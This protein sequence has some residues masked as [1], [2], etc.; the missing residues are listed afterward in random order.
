[1]YQLNLYT[2]H[3]KLPLR[4]IDIELLIIR[5]CN[6]NDQSG[7]FL[8]TCYDNETSIYAIHLYKRLYLQ[9]YRVSII[10]YLYTSYTLSSHARLAECAREQRY[11]AYEL[12]IRPMVYMHYVY[13]YYA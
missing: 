13:M 4:P 6:Q 5:P 10:L 3:E 1:M 11:L 9:Q 2:H 8:I 12:C 7:S